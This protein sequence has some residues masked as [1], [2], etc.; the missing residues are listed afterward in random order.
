MGKIQEIIE[1]KQMPGITGTRDGFG[2]KNAFKDPETGVI[3]DNWK[4][5]ERAGFY[6]PK[7]DPDIPVETRNG[8]KR[9]IEKIEKYDSGKRSSVMM[10]GE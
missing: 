6:N 4:S 2:I 9:K 3:I 10:G 8:I 5:W 7:D 1:S